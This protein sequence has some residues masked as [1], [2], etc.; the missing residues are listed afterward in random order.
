MANHER[1]MIC[2]AGPLGSSDHRVIELFGFTDFD[3]LPM[4]SVE[5]VIFTVSTTPGLLG[6]LPIENS[7]EGELTLT[8]DRLIF[9]AEDAFI[10]GEAV[11]AEEIW[12]FSL[13]GEASVHT[14]ISHSMILDLCADFI[15]H[16]GL[17][18]RHAVSTK[19][20]CDEVV[21]ARDP[22]LMALAPPSVGAQA[23][24][25]AVATEVAQV[26]ELRTRYALVANA[27]PAPTGTDRTM[28]AIV[29]RFDAVGALSEI[30]N[31]FKNHDV[32]MSSILSRP[33]AGE[34]DVH[35]F[36]VVADGHANVEPVRSLLRSLLRAGHQVKLMGCYPRWTAKDVV[37]PST[38]LPRG[39]LSYE[40][41][42]GSGA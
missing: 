23:G 34:R 39:V 35:C 38:Q 13:N 10:I 9:D 14:V 37:T 19:A 22:G 33:L 4:P 18:V 42:A 7:T 32:N 6:V 5:Q 31:H 41:A 16:R 21:S 15:R 12:G 1:P 29:P 17:S 27:L 20:A 8:L 3:P 24:L 26:S 40:E 30:A 2:F 28:L 11:L 36:V 25:N